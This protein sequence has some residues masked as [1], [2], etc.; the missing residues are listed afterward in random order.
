VG[1][2]YVKIDLAVNDEDEEEEYKVWQDNIG[3]IA[4]REAVEK[5]GFFWL[6]REAKLIEISAVLM[7]SNPITPTLEAAKSTSETTEPSNDTQK[8]ELFFK[9]LLNKN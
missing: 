2:Q 1:M 5:E 6:V 4:N 3:K 9:T 8:T 7:G